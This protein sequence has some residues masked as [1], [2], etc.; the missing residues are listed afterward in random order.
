MDAREDTRQHT[1]HSCKT[2]SKRKETPAR[3]SDF[4]R[5]ERPAHMRHA[6]ALY[7]AGVEE[8]SHAPPLGHIL[9]DYPI[10]RFASAANCLS[11]KKKSREGVPSS[12][13]VPHRATV[14]EGGAGR[15]WLMAGGAPASIGDQHLKLTHDSL[16]PPDNMEAFCRRHH[17]FKT[18]CFL[19]RSMT[20]PVRLQKTYWLSFVRI[21][22]T[23]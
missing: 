14:P 12:R 7:N 18:S 16:W 8:G 21:N 4:V 19:E 22:I 5:K 1:W 10:D 6:G 20:Y 9:E 13:F 23:L 11:P 15:A 17:P 3:C 2:I